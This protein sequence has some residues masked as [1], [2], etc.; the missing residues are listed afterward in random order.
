MP[1]NGG[2]LLEQH[3]PQWHFTPRENWMN[4]PNGL[5]YHKGI[6]HM[7]YQYN[8]ASNDWGN[9]SWG[10]ATSH[11]L[12]HWQEQPVALLARGYPKKVT[13]MF[14]SGSAVADTGN[15][16]G[17]GSA[18]EVPLVAMYTSYFPDS[19]A[20]PSGKTVKAGTQAQSIAYSLD[21]GYTWQTSDE[22]NPVIALPPAQ[23]ADEYKNHRDPF[24]FWY[25][26]DRKWVAVTVLAWLHK[27][28]IWTS[29]N[30]KE[31]TF[32][33]EFGP[34]NATGGEWECPSM[35][36]LPLN[37]VEKWVAIIGLNPG[38]PSGV[39]GSG[40]QYVVGE[41]DGRT[42]TAD[43]DSVCPPPT[44]ALSTSQKANWMDYGPDFYAAVPFNGLPANQRTAM[45][46]M[47]NWQYVRASP[48]KPWRGAMSVPRQMSLDL[49]HGKATLLQ[50][51]R[52]SISS[53]E[54]RASEYEQSWPSFVDGTESCALSGKT[55]D[56]SLSFADQ[57]S[58]A[59]TMGQFGVVLRASV[60]EA[61]GTRIGYDFA[62]KQM[63]V[64]RTKS[65]DS[66]F[67]ASFANTYYAPLAAGQDGRVS[68]RI[69]LDWSSVEVFGGQGE[70]TIT[71]QIFPSVDGDQVMLFSAGTTTKDVQLLVTI[72]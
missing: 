35:F 48:T 17:F 54:D 60:D 40:T 62:T 39:L 64:D 38:G 31:W 68:I 45:A 21:D 15:T 52:I 58:G 20:L 7:Y 10:H 47:T 30:L 16:S 71:A 41:F 61:Q 19:Q 33:S 34:V 22:C 56:I 23:Y 3:R 70:S 36:P 11:D 12:A 29:P 59:G 9:M 18:G 28:L 42:F 26:P 32:A 5:L 37:D 49:V 46:W 27:M 65:G 67:D 6:Y 43:P 50:T 24:V 8:P 55:L 13:E 69:L 14:F 44:E 53:L 57:D 66:S 25:A 4:D 2:G 51:P 1:Y 72:K 63:F